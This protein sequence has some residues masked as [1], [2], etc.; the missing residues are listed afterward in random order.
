MIYLYLKTYIMTAILLLTTVLHSET[1]LPKELRKV[2]YDRPVIKLAL[3]RAVEVR[4]LVVAVGMGPQLLGDGPL[5]RALGGVAHA[6]VQVLPLP[7]EHAAQ[8]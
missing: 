2:P 1:P 5:Q 3:H 7:L 8:G 6:A 4:L